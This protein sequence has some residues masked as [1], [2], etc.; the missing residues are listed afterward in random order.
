MP[1]KKLDSI[2]LDKATSEIW[3]LTRILQDPLFANT[4]HS[5]YD[6]RWIKSKLNSLASKIIFSFHSKYNDNSRVQDALEWNCKQR[7]DN[8]KRVL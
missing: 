3:F 4:I 2:K 6:V 7:P 5:E 1:N 8:I